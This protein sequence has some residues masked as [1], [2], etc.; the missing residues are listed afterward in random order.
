MNKVIVGNLMESVCQCDETEK[1]L[2]EYVHIL[3]ENTFNIIY[4]HTHTH[5]VLSGFC[6]DKRNITNLDSKCMVLL[7]TSVDKEYKC[8]LVRQMEPDKF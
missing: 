5:I 7:K 4:I 1:A 3:K 2:T 6:H 8:I